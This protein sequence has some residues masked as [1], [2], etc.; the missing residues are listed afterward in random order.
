MRRLHGGDA[1]TKFRRTGEAGSTSMTQAPVRVTAALI[2]DDAGRVLVARRAAGRHLAGYWEFPGGKLEPGESPEA[3]LARERRE[4]LG[5]ECEVGALRAT[6]VHAYDRGTI[7]L[8]A[9]DARWVSGEL[10]LHDHDAIEWVAPE[11]LFTIELAPADI[12]IARVLAG[13]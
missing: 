9:Y 1:A 11:G 13:R 8:L 4:E 2:V 3:C 5:I 7:E 12:P 10:V 6:S